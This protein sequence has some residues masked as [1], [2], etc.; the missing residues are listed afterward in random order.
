VQHEVDADGNHRIIVVVP[1]NL[2]EWEP[3]H[4]VSGATHFRDHPSLKW[5]DIK[6]PPRTPSSKGRS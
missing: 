1:K 5:E 6:P 3:P 4:Q 2:A